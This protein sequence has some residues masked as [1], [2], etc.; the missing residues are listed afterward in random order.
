MHAYSGVIFV[1]QDRTVR[2]QWV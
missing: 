1:C 2:I